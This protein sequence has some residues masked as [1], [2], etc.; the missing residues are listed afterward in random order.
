MLVSWVASNIALA[1]VVA[2]TAWVAQRKLALPGLAHILWLLALVKLVTPPLVGVPLGDSPGPIACALGTCG[3][4]H[5]SPT[6]TFLRDTFPWLLL[7]AWAAGAGGKA[8]VAGGRWLRFRRL[9]AH[10]RPAPAE[11][12]AL[13]TRLSRELSL[14]SPPEVLAVPGRLPP[15]VV[16]GPRRPRVLLPAALLS[17]LDPS[18]RAALLLHELVHLK[19]G[20]HLVRLLEFAVGV[21]Y[22]WLPG[23]GAIGRRLRAC[24]EACCDAAVVARLPEARRDYARLL[25]DVIDF[26][27]PPGERAVPQVTAMSAAD[28]LEKR[29]RAILDPALGSRRTRLAGAVVLALACAVLPCQLHPAFAGRP[30]PSASPTGPGP[31]A[32]FGCPTDEGCPVERIKASVCCPS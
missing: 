3:C 4:E 30:T 6:Q 23:V 27:S 25:L 26:A 9:A 14:R 18:Q 13:A 29:L 31:D 24:E 1:L 22:W 19:R 11:W 10:A 28:G 2:L 17:E 7:G 20:D 12:Q 16:S 32:G 5:H 15:L 8:A 21:A